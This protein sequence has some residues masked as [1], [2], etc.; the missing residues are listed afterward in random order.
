MERITKQYLIAG[1]IAL[2][3]VI[4]IL[5]GVMQIVPVVQIGENSVRLSLYDFKRYRLIKK[6]IADVT[7]VYP[8]KNN[9]ECWKDLV[10]IYI[11]EQIMRKA[12]IDFDI[13]NLRKIVEKQNRQYA[14][15]LHR[16]K[17]FLYDDYDKLFIFPSAVEPMF[18]RFYLKNQNDNVKR[19]MKYAEKNGLAEAS[20]K[21]GLKIKKKRVNRDLFNKKSVILIVDRYEYII[22]EAQKIDGD[23]NVIA[24]KIKRQEI[25]D[26]FKEMKEKYRI[27]VKL[28]PYS[29][30]LSK[31][32]I[33]KISD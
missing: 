17:N 30:L 29:F 3:P 23:A 1:I 22:M 15:L 8:Y 31:K 33:S 7:G 18:F 24:C 28:T 2:I 9:E 27:K 21:F 12:G 13:K 32:F 16:I 5:Y 20:K 25:S 26:F 11:K 4:L 6:M 19:I 14:G 10:N